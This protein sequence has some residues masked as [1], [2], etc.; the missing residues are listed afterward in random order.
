MEREKIAAIVLAG[1]KGKRMGSDIPKQYLSVDGHPVLYYSLRAFEES[2]LVDE[3]VL[4]VGKG[5]TDS[6]MEHMVKPW[7]IGKVR[8]VVEGGKERYHS[9]HEGLKA[10]RAADYV[11]IHDGARP[12]VTDR[13]IRDSVEGAREFGTCVAAMPVKD[14][15]KVADAEGFSAET[16]DRSSL[17]LMQTPQS[18]SYP[19]IRRAYDMLAR[20][21]AEG[22][23]VWEQLHITD[24][25]MVAETFLKIRVKLISGDYANI[26]I[27]TPEDLIVA[28]ALLKSR[29]NGNI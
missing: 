17:W 11:L 14:T 25:A 29:K 20:L 9:V 4:V 26:K 22:G 10:I 3:I 16:P 15:I 1:G 19:L 27:T 21:E 6:C 13:I 8:H 5:E 18:F 24:D 23:Q 2:P 28:E 7:N 12:L